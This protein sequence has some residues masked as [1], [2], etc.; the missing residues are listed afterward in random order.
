MES[1]DVNPNENLWH[2]LKVMP[3]VAKASW[4]A[5]VNRLEVAS[6]TTVFSV[7]CVD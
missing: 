3:I 4:T 5:C 1:P 6:L 7:L 2:E